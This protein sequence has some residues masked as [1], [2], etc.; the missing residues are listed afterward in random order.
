MTGEAM[1]TVPEE[2]SA[3]PGNPTM[4]HQA[5]AVPASRFDNITSQREIV[6]SKFVKSLAFEPP[7][8]A[9]KGMLG[10]FSQS[11]SKI[12]LEGLS[13]RVVDHDVVCTVPS[14][15]LYSGDTS[16]DT[17]ANPLPG[18][19]VSHGGDKGSIPQ[20]AA[21]VLTQ[22]DAK[23][24][25]ETTKLEQTAAQHLS[26]TT[27]WTKSSLIYAPG[28]IAKNMAASFKSLVESRIKA[29]TVLLLR[30]SLQ[31]GDNSSRNRL[32]SMLS[33]SVHLS[34]VK[35]AFT[36][37]PLP[38]SARG[39][40]QEY[41]VILP[42]LF[43]AKLT[44]GTKGEYDDVVVRAPGT[45]SANF[46]EDEL[47][48][49][50]VDVRLDTAPLLESLVEQA[51]LVVFKAVARATK[52]DEKAMGAKQGAGSS[53]SV[54][55]SSGADKISPLTP[56]SQ[57]PSS[58]NLGFKSALNLSSTPESHNEPMRLKKARSSAI[59]LNQ[60]L[61]GSGKSE[62]KQTSQ[63]NADVP[64]MNEPLSKTRKTRS[65]RWNHPQEVPARDTSN[66]PD[67]KRQRMIA[68]AARLRS[69]KSFG[70]PYA[71]GSQP[72]NATFGEFGRISS[73]DPMWG[74]D[75]KLRFHPT[76]DLHEQQD[77]SP[78]A[79]S[80][81]NASFENQRTRLSSLHGLSRNSR[82]PEEQSAESGAF[83]RTATALEGWLLSSATGKGG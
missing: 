16:K 41:D 28:A 64:M 3:P 7:P 32:L 14:L 52:A 2:E 51:R 5:F 4:E 74:R 34:S 62:E 38:P 66:F 46:A 75:G 63:H 53:T 44:A 59:R 48:L 57:T 17:R 35:T 58:L 60:I 40:Q 26:S 72:G 78:G 19:G 11:T 70:K 55:G 82:K 13:G 83:A 22:P 8:G 12:F 56:R 37:L 36:T 79:K 80:N 23:T 21:S 20:M 45:I 15:D 76:P 81:V 67:A 33:S 69:T 65:V 9:K 68:S 49:S 42:L 39:L 24:E 29:W 10:D 25:G 6:V 18:V 73:S 47:G 61:H 77:L 27:S 30:H 43:E 54:S 1:Q 71:A 31:S 50:R